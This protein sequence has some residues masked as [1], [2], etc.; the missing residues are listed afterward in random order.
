MARRS[1]ATWFALDSGSPRGVGLARSGIPH[2]EYLE[3]GELLA[4]P[5]SVADWQVPR[6]ELRDGA[7]AD[8]QP[9]SFPRVFST[10]LRDLIVEL[11]PASPF[12][13]LRVDVVSEDG[14]HRSYVTPS[15][16]E[17]PDIFD[18]VVERPDGQI[19]HARL[20]HAEADRYRFFGYWKGMDQLVLYGH[21][22]LRAAVKQAACDVGIKWRTTPAISWPGDPPPSPSARQEPS[23]RWGLGDLPAEVRSALAV[24]GRLLEHQPRSH[25][26]AGAVGLLHPDR[27]RARTVPVERVDS[28]EVEP[29]T[30]ID[31]VDAADWGSDLLVWLPELHLF[32]GYNGDHAEMIVFPGIGWSDIAAAP[33]EYLNA[34]WANPLYYRDRPVPGERFDPL[35]RT[36]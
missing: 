11:S 30:V 34:M 14:E 29:V 15:L 20:D 9:S 24:G 6:L 5:G 23:A 18:D 32:G 25:S 2:A 28:G 19:L 27:V 4:R 21:R 8:L 33:G 31:I 26:E 13:W 1:P 22:E 12:E 7:F 17:Q 35:H 10:D 36:S 16:L 3:L